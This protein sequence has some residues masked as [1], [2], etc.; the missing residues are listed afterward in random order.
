[1]G[2]ESM[3]KPIALHFW[4]TPNGHKITIALEEMGLPYEIHPVNIGAGDQ[5][6]PEFQALSPNGRMPAIVDPAG[7]DDQPISIFESG[8]IL[9]HLAKKTGQ[10]YGKDERARIAVDEWLF[11]QVGGLGPMLGQANHF[12]VY[13]QGV[14][15]DQ[16]QLAYGANRYTNE[17]HRLFGVLE[18][19]LDGRDYLAGDY[20]IADMASWPWANAWKNM[21]IVIEEFPRVGAWLE[22]IAERPAVKRAMARGEEIRSG[23]LR[24]TPAE[25]EA[26]RKV[27]FGQRGR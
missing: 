9:Q 25:Q 27:L 3:A 22:R 13:A 23:G 20:S 10:F 24:G 16:R 14:T 8:A 4:P 2:D 7:P 19:Q 11:W 17:A 18:K 5:F 15:G 12:R 26:A 21:G 1:M 6:K